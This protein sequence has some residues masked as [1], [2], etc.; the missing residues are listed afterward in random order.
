MTSE[1]SWSFWGS[2]RDPAGFEAGLARNQG[3][4]K[5]S[6]RL[7]RSYGFVLSSLVT[8]S[9]ATP[10]KALGHLILNLRML[11]KSSF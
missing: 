2:G 6:S 8:K 5:T 9:F 7:I 3:C 4:S 1:S 11:S 10:G